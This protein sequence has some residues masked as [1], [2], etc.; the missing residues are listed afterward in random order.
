VRRPLPPLVVLAVLLASAALAH[1]APW[2]SE[3]APCQPRDTTDA[4]R[5]A[6][7]ALGAAAGAPAEDA[8][9]GSVAAADRAS[10]GGA[11]A[12]DEQARWSCGFAA[13]YHDATMRE[14]DQAPP[15]GGDLLWA[16][17][18]VRFA[19]GTCALTFVL[20]PQAGIEGIAGGVNDL[21]LGKAEEGLAA[22]TTILVG[23]PG[24]VLATARQA[25]A[26]AVGVACSAGVAAEAVRGAGSSAGEA[27][28]AAATGLPPPGPAPAGT[29]CDAVRLLPRA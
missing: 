6:L 13:W 4:A 20:N 21:A 8:V 2:P 12:A 26:V 10:G 16:S 19:L 24:S 9:E 11:T 22:G 18:A 7:L 23:S 28:V 14:V 1:A 29:I 17:C 3:G 25:Q 5:E 27:A 15:P